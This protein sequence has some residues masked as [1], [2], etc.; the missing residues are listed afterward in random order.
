MLN[1]TFFGDPMTNNFILRPIFSE[2]SEPLS[3][4]VH[5]TPKQADEAISVLQKSINRDC[6]SFAS[7]G[8]SSAALDIHFSMEEA[9]SALVDSAMLSKK[10]KKKRRSLRRGWLFGQCRKGVCS[11]RSSYGITS[12]F[13]CMP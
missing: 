10:K 4:A 3:P 11:S 1:T 6:K 9:S 2:D 13:D 12:I 7:F 5:F 8:T